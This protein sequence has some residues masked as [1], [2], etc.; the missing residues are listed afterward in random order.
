MNFFCKTASLTCAIVVLAMKGMAQ[1]PVTL[2]RLFD[3]ADAQSW[4]IRVSQSGL[5]ASSEAVA[6][7]KSALLP[8]VNL[9]AN[10][11]YIGDATLM[12]RGFS[13]S[14]T[15]DVILAGL[16][17]QKVTNGRQPTP[18]W[19]NTFSV[20]ATQVIYAGGAIRA[21][22]RMAELGEKM[23]YLDVE[24][25]RQEVRFLI[26][27]YYLDLYK[28][29]NQLEVVRENIGITEKLIRNME[30][31]HEQGTVLKNDIIRYELQLKNLQLTEEKL[32][33]AT[34]IINHQ[35]VT[36]LHLDENTI[37][38]PDTLLL[39][40]ES[41]SL[42]DVV[43]QNLWQQ[44]AEQNNIGIKQASVAEEIAGHKV[45]KSRAA[46]LPSVA[47]VAEDNL[48]GP[49]TSDLI[50]VNA[51]VNAWFV[52]I[53][54]KYSLSSIWSNKHTIRKAK[55][56]HRQAAEQVNL[57]REGVENGVQACFVN[58]LTAFKEV[59]TQEK[60]VELAEQNYGV[61]NNRYGESLA[62]LTDML[63]ASAMKLNAEME[64]VNARMSLLY[65]YY[66]LKYLTNTL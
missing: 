33:D 18:H 42:K 36:T 35:L 16:G 55:F 40:A 58:F 9:S 13:T 20:Q 26:A 44:R 19:G 51:N 53:G 60:Q 21:G 2:N 25:N 34:S 41:Q 57:A 14:G 32:M 31:R 28:L 49:Y 1:E 4:K 10:G 61:V 6:A 52:G 22:I 38:V 37:I 11:S 27:G 54:V 17:P 7:A 62:L 47:F 65:N 59:E 48:F 8:S 45:R 63:D 30:A 5:D 15:T 43:S 24:K 66:K 3:I 29:H 64:L 46:S 23:A 50:P 12:S 39:H 56:E